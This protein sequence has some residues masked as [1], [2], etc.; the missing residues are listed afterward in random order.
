METAPNQ[1]FKNILNIYNSPLKSEDSL[2]FIE[3]CVPD[4]ALGILHFSL[5]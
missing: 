5:I 2:T 4:T 1:T 3:H